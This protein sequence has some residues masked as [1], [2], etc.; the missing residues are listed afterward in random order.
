M[1]HWLRVREHHVKKIKRR[2]DRYKDRL[3][4]L[5]QKTHPSDLS[6]SAGDQPSKQ[7]DAAPMGTNL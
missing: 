4:L 5:L 2:T 1:T 7:Q 3:K 6:N